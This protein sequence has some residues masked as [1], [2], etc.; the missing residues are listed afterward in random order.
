MHSD[1]LRALHRCDHRAGHAADNPL[2]RW[3]VQQLSYHRFARHADQQRQ[4]ETMKF[5]QPGQKLIVVRQIFTETEA[6]VEQQFL[7]CYPRLVTAP[8]MVLEKRL[9]VGDQIVVVRRLLHGARLPLHVHQADRQ[10]AFRR[11]RRGAA[12]AESECR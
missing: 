4:T 10:T 5:R 12:P 7:I 8:D 9:N 1:N 6:R 2:I 3:H 11:R